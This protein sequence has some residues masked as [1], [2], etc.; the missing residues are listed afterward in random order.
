LVRIVHDQ[1]LILWPVHQVGGKRYSQKNTD[2][3]QTIPKVM[4]TCLNS[5]FPTEKAGFL[6]SELAL[7]AF[8]AFFRNVLVLGDSDAICE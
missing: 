5:I 6:G 4:P 1:T 7:G 3:N 8:S 2:Q